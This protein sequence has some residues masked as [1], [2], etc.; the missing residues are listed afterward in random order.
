TVLRV[1]IGSPSD[2]SSER[3]AIREIISQWNYV[4]AEDRKLVLMPV[5]WE[6]H[7]TPTMGER[8]QAIINRQVLASCDLLV[9]VFWTR[10]GSPTGLAP[11]GTVEE[12]DEHLQAGKPA[13]LYF[14]SAPVLPDSVDQQQYAAL[15]TFKK[16][17]YDKGLVESYGTVGEFRDKFSRQLS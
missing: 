3:Q 2:V 15:K 5:G 4:H 14:S 17:C 1:M 13:M 6:T 9:A 11:S 8:P 10:L 7:S 12:I 16:E